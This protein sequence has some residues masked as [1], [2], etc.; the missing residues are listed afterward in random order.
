M[1]AMGV[2]HSLGEQ[3]VDERDYA[4]ENVRHDGHCELGQEQKA[5]PVQ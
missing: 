2:G 3:A 5:E 4:P 1:R